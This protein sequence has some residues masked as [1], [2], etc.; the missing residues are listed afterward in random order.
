MTLVRASVGLLDDRATRASREGIV[1]I[2]VNGVSVGIYYS[3]Q[4]GLRSVTPVAF[5]IVVVHAIFPK[6]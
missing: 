4:I 2:V 6:T 3:Y 1:V 5:T